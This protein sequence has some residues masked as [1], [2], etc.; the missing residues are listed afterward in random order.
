MTE[1]RG[2]E[3]MEKQNMATAREMRE[4]ELEREK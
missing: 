2:E 3:K 4:L 1:V